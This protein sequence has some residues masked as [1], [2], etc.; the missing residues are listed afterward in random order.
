MGS[1]KWGQVQ[2]KLCVPPFLNFART[3]VFTADITTCTAH[4]IEAGA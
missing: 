1:D 2:I 3:Q 4:R